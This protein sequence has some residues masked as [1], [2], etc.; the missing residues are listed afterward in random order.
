[1]IKKKFIKT[2]C[3]LSFCYLTTAPACF[4]VGIYEMTYCN[5]YVDNYNSGTIGGGITGWGSCM[6]GPVLIYPNVKPKLLFNVPKHGKLHV[7]NYGAAITPSKVPNQKVFSDSPLTIRYRAFERD[8]HITRYES[9]LT[10]DLSYQ[11]YSINNF[12]NNP[13]YVDVSAKVDTFDTEITVPRRIIVDD[14]YSGTELNVRY[15]VGFALPDAS[16]SA[17]L[18]GKLEVSTMYRRVGNYFG[19]RF[20]PETLDLTCGAEVDCSGTVNI[21]K[22]TDATNARATCRTDGYSNADLSVET[23]GAGGWVRLNSGGPNEIVDVERLLN[24]LRVTVLRRKTG[25]AR[26]ERVNLHCSLI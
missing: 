2:I 7:Y 6:D 17:E 11:G 23:G 24:K 5:G 16:S 13:H 22:I 21:L 26:K 18:L 3:S 9:I 20:S 15:R 19:L 1:M 12:T 8:D 4:A 10:A 25:T 14:P